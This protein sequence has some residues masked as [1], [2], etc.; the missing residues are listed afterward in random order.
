MSCIAVHVH[1][2]RK[3]VIRFDL[4]QPLHGKDGKTQAGRFINLDT[5]LEMKEIVFKRRGFYEC[6]TYYA[7]VD[8]KNVCKT[9]FGLTKTIASCIS[10]NLMRNDDEECHT[11]EKVFIKKESTVASFTNFNVTSRLDHYY[12]TYRFLDE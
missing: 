9:E 2:V 6:S 1:E 11:V 12:C 7:G 8:I 5:G 3:E 10:K 4:A